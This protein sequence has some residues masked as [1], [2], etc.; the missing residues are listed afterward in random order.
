MH[1]V[2][3]PGGV[4]SEQAAVG[5]VGVQ[6]EICADSLL[7]SPEGAEPYCLLAQSC[8]LEV[9]GA[10]GN[11]VFC[12]NPERTLT[13]FS[14]ASGFL[15]ALACHKNPNL[16][17]Q[18][19]EMVQTIRRRKAKRAAGWLVFFGL[20]L[21]LVCC[22]LYSAKGLS[23]TA[24]ESMPWQWDEALGQ[25]LVTQM[26]LGGPV[27]ENLVVQDAA[28]RILQRLVPHSA[29]PDGQFEIRVVKSEQ[30]NAFALPG[31]QMVVF[32]GLL[33]NADRAEEV[34]G[35]LAHE[36]AHVTE[37]HGIERMVQSLGLVAMVQLALGDASG[38]LGLGA[39][40][41]TITAINR[42]SQDQE[43]EAD[44]VG[45][46]ILQK[47]GI[48]HEHLAAFFEHLKQDQQEATPALSPNMQEV[49]SWV[50]THPALDS[51]VEAINELSKALG[52]VVEA[53]IDIDWGAVKTALSEEQ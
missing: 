15:H 32:T 26:D 23:E 10:S 20:T 2:T 35:V 45:V 39:E 53:P 24:V 6:I 14:E 42:Y 1:E 12:R 30:V 25:T 8:L 38:L 31:G 9:G 21:S 40:L 41:L 52:P 37:R 19:Q 7:A 3:F 29:R 33:E 44:A 36:I 47:A 4:F 50:S 16:R 34:A 48:S 11:M 17:H 13:I 49:L 46:R 18:A 51:R 22:A 43:S 5:R 28:N 27:V